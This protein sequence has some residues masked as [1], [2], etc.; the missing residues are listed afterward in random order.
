[1]GDDREDSRGDRRLGG[2]LEAAPVGLELRTTPERPTA[3][4]MRQLGDPTGCDEAP[5]AFAA[6]VICVGCVRSVA[7]DAS[8]LAVE[9]RS[10]KV[11]SR[12]LASRPGR[13]PE[14]AAD[15]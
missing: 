3:N 4:V 6:S 13:R 5:T 2:R 14:G 11:E 1:M 12:R 7:E 15:V 9:T 8:L 10:T